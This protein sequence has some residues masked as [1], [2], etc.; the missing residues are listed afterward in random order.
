MP[1]FPSYVGEV[2]MKLF[3]NRREDLGL[4]LLK[5]FL[6]LRFFFCRFHRCL[7]SLFIY[8]STA[9]HIWALITADI[10]NKIEI[11]RVCSFGWMHSILSFPS[12]SLTVT[13]RG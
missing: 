10:L 3:W 5:F 6:F 2:A 9:L 7:S 8:A 1:F 13:Q 4:P 11:S 12:L